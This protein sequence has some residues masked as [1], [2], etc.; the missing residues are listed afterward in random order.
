MQCNARVYT[1]KYSS[2]L[3]SE[4]TQHV[5]GCMVCR[6]TAV[7]S[8][9]GVWEERGGVA[10]SGAAAFVAALIGTSSTPVLQLTA[11]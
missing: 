7:M 10:S 11:L 3:L 9:C 4:C 8:W 2:Q 6:A 5:A 1:I